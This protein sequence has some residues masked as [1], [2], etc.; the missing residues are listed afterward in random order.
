[1]Q[2]GYRTQH[3]SSR[4]IAN[5]PVLSVITV[6]YN[7]AS[8]IERTLS[9][10]IDQT[11]SNIEY[12]VVDGR[13]KDNTLDLVKSH[14]DKI[15]IWN[16]EKDKGIYDAM[17]KGLELAS[18]DYILFM[19]A[20]DQFFSKNTVETI[21]AN[22]I[23]GDIYYG[24]TLIVDEEGNSLGPR[25]LRPPHKLTWRSFRYGML[26]CHQS[27]IVRRSLAPVYDPHYKIAADIDW[28]IKCLKNAT[29]IIN[30]NIVIARYLS[31]G[32]SWQNQKKALAER[33]ELMTK[34]Y[35]TVSVVASH[36]AIVVRYIKHRL[37]KGKL[38]N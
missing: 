11:Y 28:C 37:F 19:N 32:A 9:S 2:G 38:S 21:F 17:N 4:K 1:M 14:E 25:R 23:D 30:T 33:F 13:S 8:L 24:D 35:G 12:V 29:K 3:I 22:D 6:V 7:G 20:G 26:V 16:S 27:F 10:V 5:L 34:H 18:G 36:A 15:A 31:G